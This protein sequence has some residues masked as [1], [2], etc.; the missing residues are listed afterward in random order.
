M[1]LD[2]Q[3]ATVVTGLP[4]DTVYTKIAKTGKTINSAKVDGEPKAIAAA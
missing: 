4:F 3:S 2:R 1:S